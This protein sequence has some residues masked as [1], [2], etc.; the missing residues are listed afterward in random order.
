MAT[1]VELPMLSL[2]REGPLHG[3]ELKRR[4]ESLVGFFGAVSYGSVYP[5]FRALESRQYV[6]H[7]PEEFGRII[8][9]I[10]SKGK[11]RFVQLM[12]D[13]TVT[14][15]QKLLFLEAIPPAERREILESHKEEWTNRLEQYRRIQERID[16]KAIGRY[17]AA[18]L[19]REIDHLAK[20]IIW[21][22]QL[23]DDEEANTSGRDGRDG[24]RGPLKSSRRK[25]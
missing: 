13:P 3:Y 18:L 12:H 14:L 6:T 9:H 23:I 15:T 19:K 7:T 24:H 5:M 21:L 17:R 1:S 2:L 4:L 25:R 16:S 11:A 22:Q 20:D 10:T 8:Y